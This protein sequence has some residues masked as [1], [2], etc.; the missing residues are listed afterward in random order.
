[1]ENL[2]LYAELLE[3]SSNANK[4]FIKSEMALND[5]N[6][7]DCQKFSKEGQVLV[8]ALMKDTFIEIEENDGSTNDYDYPN[9]FELIKSL[10]E[11]AVNVGSLIASI[12][13]ENVTKICLPSLFK[14]INT[15]KE[16]YS[17]L[18]ENWNAIN[19]VLINLF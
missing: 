13:D 12:D 9:N 1:M 10:N 14:A 16:I 4:A 15:T 3:A 6:V 8:R 2:A 17:A 11:I 18:F 7:E 5:G 19:L